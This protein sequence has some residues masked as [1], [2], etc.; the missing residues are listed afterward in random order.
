MKFEMCW[1]CEGSA[2]VEADDADEAEDLMRDA[3]EHFSTMDLE[4]FDVDDTEITETTE[5]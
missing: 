5:K 3:L 2:T 1:R 4:S